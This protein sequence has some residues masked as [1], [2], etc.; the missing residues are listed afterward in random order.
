MPSLLKLTVLTV[1]ECDFLRRSWGWFVALGVLLILLGFMGL[2]FVGI[3]TLVTVLMIGWLFLV[4]GVAEVVL[5]LLRQGWS[6][7]WL[8]LLSGLVTAVV[9]LL[10]VLRPETGASV[11]TVV[12][13]VI[14]LVGGVF[15][16]ATGV[17]AKNPYAGWFLL[18][19]ILALLLGLLILIEWPV[20]SA[21]VIGT[22]ICI[23]LLFNGLRLISFGWAIKAWLRTHRD[24]PVPTV[25][26]P[27]SWN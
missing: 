21:W 3:A 7:F 13:G 12:I 5:A 18:Q 2:V 27:A 16:L 9:G 15:R 19:G 25:P 10:L 22:L 20:S 11:L 4:A 23:D 26:P 8:D 1:D 24:E 14:F 6:G 17:I